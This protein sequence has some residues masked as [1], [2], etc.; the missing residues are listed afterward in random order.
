AK[1]APASQW[2]DL[3]ALRGQRPLPGY[4]GLRAAVAG[5]LAGEGR[6]ALRLDPEKAQAVL[7]LVDALGPARAPRAE[8]PAGKG[9]AASQLALALQASVALLRAGP[10]DEAAALLEGEDE[11]ARWFELAARQ[12]PRGPRLS[13]ET[14]PFALEGL[15]AGQ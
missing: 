6:A 5:N 12:G 3:G 1:V 10:E 9:A 7:D 13:P 14:L 15:C 4:A 2:L 8:L 11:L